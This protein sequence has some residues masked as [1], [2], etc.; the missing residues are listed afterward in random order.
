VSDEDGIDNIWSLELETGE[1]KQLTHYRVDGVQWPAIASQ[2]EYIV[3]EFNGGLNIL[4]LDKGQARTLTL[5][6]SSEVKENTVLKHSFADDAD[7]YCVSPHGKYAVIVHAGDLWAVK[8]PESYDEDEKP[9]QDL[10]KA[11]RLTASDGSR[12]RQPA[13]APD[14]RQLAYASD[15]DGDYEIYVM[16]LDDMSIR[17]VTDNDVDDL[18]PAFSP[19]DSNV[20]F[21]YTGNSQLARHELES[22][23]TNVVAEG[24]LRSAFGYYGYSVSPDGAWVVYAEELQDWSAEVYIVDSNGKTEPVNITRHPGW[25]DSPRWSADGRRLIFRGRRDD[26]SSIYAVDLMP[27]PATYD[28]TFLFEDDRPGFEKKK[29]KN[30]KNPEDD[31]GEENDEENGDGDDENGDD[32]DDDA[33]DNDDDKAVKVEIDFTDIHLRA[34]RVTDQDDARNAVISDDGEWV[35]YGC[36]P[37]GAGR[38]VWSVKAEGGDAGKLFDGDWDQPAFAAKGKRVYYRDGGAVKYFKFSGGKDKGRETIH[39][40]GEFWLD[41]R[42][43]WRQMY[44]EGWRTLRERFYDPALHGT[45]W[46]AHYE[47][48]QSCVEALGTPEEFGLMFEELLGELNASHLA[49]YMA[50]SSYEGEGVTTGHLG[51]EFDQDYAGP[52]LKVKHVTYQGPVRWLM[53]V[54]VGQ[55]CWTT[56][57]DT[58]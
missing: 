14:N 13:F 15:A 19:A 33:D 56:L 34:R 3:V 54:S 32:N 6:V 11:W 36:D 26:E 16:D 10:A 18:S 38:E 35:V 2:G 47:K 45:D 49:I 58:P 52:G 51:L 28:M 20:L 17:Q 30:G 41:Q 44:R 40:N 12:E 43:R 7:E 46:D 1:K 31:E 4:P 25:D 5:T 42:E 57:L 22:G 23:K 53:S 55:L 29:H 27:E 8:D 9:D 39:A 24:R 48:Y 37:D 50:E 21:Y